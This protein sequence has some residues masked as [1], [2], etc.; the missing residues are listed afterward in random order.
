MRHLA[1]VIPALAAAAVPAAA[2][3][4]AS[5]RAAQVAV[6]RCYAAID[7][8]D[9]RSAY[10]LW[11]ENGRRGQ[12]YAQFVRGFAQTAATRVVAGRP[13][14]QEGAAGSTFITVPVDVHAR[15]KNGRRQHFRGE[16][17]MRRVNGVDGATP[18][19]LA[20]HIDQARLRAVR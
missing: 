2:A 4:D 12:T 18:A 1:L 7:R 16:Y 13:R 8:G 3:I 14:D 19:Q 5:S 10:R 17:V 20:W 6:E 9:F 11:G 15:L